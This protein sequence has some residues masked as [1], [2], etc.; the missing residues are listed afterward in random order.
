MVD[1]RPI[2]LG[3]WDTAGQ[4]DYDRL[5]PLSYPQTDV[6]LVCFAINNQASSENVKSKWEPDFRL[7]FRLDIFRGSLIINGKANQEH[8]SL[9]IRQRPQ[10]VVVLLSSSVPQTQV[11]RTTVDH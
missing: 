6:F 1:G 4:E 11:N 5:R 7:P 2:N 3:L 8:I 9:R 10:T